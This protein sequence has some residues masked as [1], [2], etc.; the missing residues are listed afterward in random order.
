MSQARLCCTTP[1]PCLSLLQLPQGVDYAN[2]NGNQGSY[3]S[4]DELSFEELISGIGG[5]GS[6]SSSSGS[7]SPTASATPPQQAPSPSGSCWVVATRWATPTSRAGPYPGT[8]T[9]L[10]CDATQPPLQDARHSA[11]TLSSPDL[12]RLPAPSAGGP[13]A[14]AS[15][16]TTT[17]SA[18][19]A[20]APTPTSPPA[21]PSPSAAAPRT[22]ACACPTCASWQ[23]LQRARASAPPT[24]TCAS[25]AR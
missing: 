25:P 22:A 6:P 7:G 15:A 9:A 4:T 24:R 23:T 1:P 19:A 3:S 17:P 16:R 14:P 11:D 2:S 20:G 21:A 5:G 18:S 10:R 12:A 13:S 8:A